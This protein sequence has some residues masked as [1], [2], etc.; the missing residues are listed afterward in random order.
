MRSIRSIINCPSVEIM[1]SQGYS[2]A[3]LNRGQKWYQF[4]GLPLT[5]TADVEF[6][7]LQETC[8]LNCKKQVSAA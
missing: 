4:I 8:S 5:L 3:R 1:T 7:L 6:L 2:P